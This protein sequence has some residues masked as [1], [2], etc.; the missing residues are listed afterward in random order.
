MIGAQDLWKKGIMGNN[1]IIAILDTGLDVT[2]PN[3][4]H[5]GTD[6]KAKKVIKEISMID[7]PEE[8]GDTSDQ[9]G[10][11]THVAGIASSNGAAGSPTFI[12]TAVGTQILNATILPN[13]QMGVAPMAKLYNVKVL[14]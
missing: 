7:I 13:T 1:T 12:G 14:S 10:H 5:L 4:D 11:G 6:Q 3:L 2:H 8:E 9:V